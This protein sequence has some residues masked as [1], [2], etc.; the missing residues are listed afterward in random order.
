M[1]ENPNGW[2]EYQRLVLDKLDDHSRQLREI[3]SKQQ[4]ILQDVS[5]LKAKS[6]MIAAT[7]GVIAALAVRYVS[8]HL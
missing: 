5:G 1:T 4:T 2:D 7:F 3:T 8:A 6:A